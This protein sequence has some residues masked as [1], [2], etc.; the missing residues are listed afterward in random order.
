M[1]LELLLGERR[2]ALQRLVSQR[3]SAHLLRQACEFLKG[4]Q[5]VCAGRVSRKK[6]GVEKQSAG[7]GRTAACRSAASRGH[8]GLVDVIIYL[9]SKVH[10]TMHSEQIIYIN[11]AYIR[12][13]KTIYLFLF[14][15]KSTHFGTAGSS[16]RALESEIAV[17]GSGSACASHSST[18]RGAGSASRPSG[19]PL[20]LSGELSMD[21]FYCVM[22][23]PS[24]LNSKACAGAH[25]LS[26][27]TFRREHESR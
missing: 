12:I 21:F 13:F 8:A 5:P 17:S 20:T 4:V 9:T 23:V 10:L 18:R 15:Q 16:T 22:C 14:S 7:G 6:T 27:H 24:A 19:C 25:G 1:V 3:A 11:Y 2:V 26:G